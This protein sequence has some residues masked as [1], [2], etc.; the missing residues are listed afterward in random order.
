[1]GK[2]QISI[3]ANF[4]YL[5]TGAVMIPISLSTTF[6]QTEVGVKYEGGNF[7]I[8]L[9]LYNKFLKFSEYSRSAN[10]TRN[11][12]EKCIADADGKFLT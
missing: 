11:A 10:P 12:L 9:G 7:N 4:F 6:A 3:L 1:V 2:N 8:K 5:Y